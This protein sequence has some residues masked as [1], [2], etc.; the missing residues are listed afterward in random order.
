MCIHNYAKAKKRKRV[1]ELLLYSRWI[2][3]FHSRGVTIH[4]HYSFIHYSFYREDGSEIRAVRAYT[5]LPLAV[6]D[7]D[8]GHYPNEKTNDDRG[9]VPLWRR[10]F[11]MIVSGGSWI[12]RAPR[13]GDSNECIIISVQ[14]TQ[15]K[16]KSSKA[17]TQTETRFPLRYSILQSVSD[18]QMEEP[19]SVDLTRRPLFET[20]LIAKCDDHFRSPPGS[21]QIS[22]LHTHISPNPLLAPPLFMTTCQMSKLCSV[23]GN[24]ESP[25]ELIGR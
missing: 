1:K 12:P 15:S 24:Y 10:R 20:H 2:N 16:D 18:L 3:S 22:P 25:P 9:A 14:R 19:L 23:I 6:V 13:Q 8:F 5:F 21:Q 17:S 4:I 7:V 11:E